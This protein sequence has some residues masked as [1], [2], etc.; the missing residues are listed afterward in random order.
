VVKK[1]E[2]FITSPSPVDT[3]KPESAGSV[4]SGNARVTSATLA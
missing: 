3:R 2:A 1:V 4:A